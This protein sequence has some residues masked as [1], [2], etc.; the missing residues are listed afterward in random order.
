MT[1]NT[2]IEHNRTSSPLLRLPQELRDQIYGYLHYTSFLTKEEGPLPR[3]YCRRKFRYLV[4][5][6]LALSQVCRQLRDEAD[7]QSLTFS[8]VEE[9]GGILFNTV[10]MLPRQQGVT[11]VNWIKRLPTK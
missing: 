10:V 9:D 8:V 4:P 3:M 5:N 1:T 2:I 7:L 11:W 6:V